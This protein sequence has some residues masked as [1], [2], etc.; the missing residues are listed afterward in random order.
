MKKLLALAVAAT[1]AAAVAVPAL[2]ATRTVKVGDN[3]FLRAGAPPTITIKKGDTVKWT[4]VGRSKHN[5]YQVGG[6]GH[7]HS[8]SQKTG[9]YKHRFTKRGIYK[10][11]CTFHLP[12]KMTIK[13][14]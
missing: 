9:T 12:Q 5:V 2:A 1:T 14:T 3:Y 6:P 7:F 11:Q 4:W 8:P 13:V 10:F